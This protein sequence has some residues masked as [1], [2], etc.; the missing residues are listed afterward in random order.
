MKQA[1]TAVLKGHLALAQATFP[2]G[3]TGHQL[4]ILARQYLWKLGLD[5]DHGTG[6]GVGCFLNVHEGP[7]TI[8]KRQNTTPLEP[9]MI[10]SNEPGYYKAEEFGIRIES[11]VLV[12][13]KIPSSTADRDRIFYEFET[14]TLA[15]LDL[16][17]IDW[18]MIT[19]NEKEWIQFYHKKIFETLA[20]TL[21]DQ[22]REWLQAFIF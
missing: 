4:D 16:K 11:L 19:P 8:S 13:E 2:K 1:Y 14:L 18:Q 21:S 7:Q 20:P 6:H 5:Y 22:E 10:L 17:L 12:K 9:G 3:T 15:P